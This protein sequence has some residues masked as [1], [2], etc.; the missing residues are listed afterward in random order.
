MKQLE[1]FS[2]QDRDLVIKELEKIQKAKL[3]V[4]KP[5]RKFFT[6]NDGKFHCIFGGCEDWHGISSALMQHLEIHKNET[7]LVIAKKYKTRIDICVGTVEKI[8]EQKDKLPRT[9]QDGF[10]FHTILTE[11][12]M[13][14]EEI[15]EVKL[16]K[17]SEV[18]L[19]SLA[20]TSFDLSEI[21]KIVNLELLPSFSNIEQSE[22]L[23]HSDIEA[24]ILLVG[25]WLGHRTFT[26][27][28]G[29]VSRYG[30]LGD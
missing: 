24:K 10:Q 6:D 26:P 23:T 13:Y 19:S 11:D 28:I 12:G 3:E 7:L 30:K 4:V 25:K 20:E 9:K 16:K 22:E 8:V 5:S 18:V 29:K 15:P 27:D 17:I 1:K 2:T 21:K 14:F